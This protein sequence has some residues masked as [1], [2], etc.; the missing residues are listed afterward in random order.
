MQLIS[1]VKDRDSPPNSDRIYTWMCVC[2]CV[3]A[4]VCVCVCVC[5][6]VS[7]CVRLKQQILGQLGSLVQTFTSPK[8]LY[9]TENLC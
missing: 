4:R 3:R 2:V 6:D 1:I 5:G 7:M 8:V 9:S